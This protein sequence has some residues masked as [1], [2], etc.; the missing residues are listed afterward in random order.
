MGNMWA[1]AEIDHRA[2]AVYSSGGAVG[3][4]GLDEV[5]LVFVV[6]QQSMRNEKLVDQRKDLH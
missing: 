1:N 5:L 6:L 2:A 4:F 3:N